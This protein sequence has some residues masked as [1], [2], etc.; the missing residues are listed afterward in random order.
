MYLDWMIYLLTGVFTGLFAGL[1]GV[2]GGVIAVP[3]LIL[4]FQYHHLFA[5]DYIMHAAAA[6]SLAAMILTSGSSA[7]AYQRRGALMW[8]IFWRVF[9]G[10][11]IGLALGVVVTKYLDN[12]LLVDLFAI[13]LVI[14]ALDLMLYPKGRIQSSRQPRKLSFRTMFATSLV[15][16]V[17]T[18]CFG[19]G[20][21]VLL[22]PLFLFMGLSMHQAS[23]TS[24]LCGVLVALTGTVLMTLL[25]LWDE[26][27]QIY[28][29]GTVG[30]VYWPAAFCLAMTSVISAPLG[31]QLSFNLSTVTLKRLFALL[32]MIS[33][34]NLLT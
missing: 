3:I 29:W 9:P 17:L 8:P 7:L 2:G 24:S 4:D 28:P 22:V 32:L 15:V 21:G 18:M 27:N 5:N 19:I 13:F 1:L 34:W 23:G 31:T 33:V 30:Y 14:I 6:T 16:G 26:S 25:G 11:V 12:A 10:L 20:G